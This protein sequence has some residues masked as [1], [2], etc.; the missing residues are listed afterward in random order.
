MAEINLFD[1]GIGV[2]LGAFVG[3]RSDSALDIVA[4]MLILL[5]IHLLKNNLS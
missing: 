4:I 1:L 3:F 5:G 2:G